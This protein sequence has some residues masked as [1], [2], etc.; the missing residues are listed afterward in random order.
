MSEQRDGGLVDWPLAER[1]A[2]GL[3]RIR[4]APE[5]PVS[6]EDLESAAERSI[7]LVTE[8]TGLDPREAMPEP[9]I[10][11]REEWIR[12]TIETFRDAAGRIEEQLAAR[13][14]TG[15]KGSSAMRTLARTATGL[16]VG[17]VA[18]YLSQ[19]VLGQYDVALI[20]PA[21]PPRLLFVAPNLAE[22]QHKLHAE[23]GPF[24]RWIALHETTH[25]VQFSAVPWLRGHLGEM[26]EELL[27][28]ATVRLGAKDLAA[29][30]GR[31]VST[32]LRELADT[33]RRGELATLL[34]GPEQRQQFKRVQ[35]A[36]AVVEGY[37]EHVMDAVGLKLDPAYSELR[38]RTD[39]LRE[40]RGRL[41]AVIGRLLGLDA[42]LLQY[43]RGKDFADAVAEQAG[44]AGLN[45][46]WEAPELLPSPDELERPE[47]WLERTAL[48]RQ[49]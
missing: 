39:R 29:L 44:V 45:R 6:A 19:R 36:M 31:L 42:K 28:G 26:A 27:T 35:A 43:R 24:L 47:A 7:E 23:R 3:T 9:E 10:V 34:L 5:H 41:D 21:R 46:V 2:I 12:A 22:A 20:G 1:V 4:P 13:L 15:E 30:F 11:G 48:V 32:E 17:L 16:E 8:Y 18:A 14:E 25:A 37:S 49:A 38:A 33:V 40:E